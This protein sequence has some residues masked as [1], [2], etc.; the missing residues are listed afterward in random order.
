MYRLRVFHSSQDG[1]F[2][3]TEIIYSYTR[4]DFDFERRSS[5]GVQLTCDCVNSIWKLKKYTFESNKETR[6]KSSKYILVS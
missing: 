3:I 4:D 2:I 6:N 5:Y 1:S